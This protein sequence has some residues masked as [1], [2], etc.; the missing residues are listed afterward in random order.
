[1]RVAIL[2]YIYPFLL[3][4]KKSK[5]N[6]SRPAHQTSYIFVNVFLA[7]TLIVE[8]FRNILIVLENIRIK[9]MDVI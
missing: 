9:K 6:P 1:M 2:L 4:W 3:N 8:N 5:Y 7:H